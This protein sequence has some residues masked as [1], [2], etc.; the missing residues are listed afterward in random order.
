MPSRS[1]LAV[2]GRCP[3]SCP[4]RHAAAAAAQAPLVPLVPKAAEIL[5]AGEHRPQPSMVSLDEPTHARLRK[6]AARAFSVTRIQA[7]IPA[8]ETTAA[9]LLDAVTGQGQF[10][11][12]AALAFP[13]PANIVF[14]LIGVPESDFGQLKR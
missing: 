13:L 6:P 9:R 12:V 8:I 14:S 5:L 11:L 10:D 3:D 7:M 4:A 2:H 1:R